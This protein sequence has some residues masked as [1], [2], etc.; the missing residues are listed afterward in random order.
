MIATYPG[1]PNKYTWDLAVHELHLCQAI[2][3]LNFV[4]SR[5]NTP[6]SDLFSLWFAEGGGCK[7]KPLGK[8][9]HQVVRVVVQV[10]QVG[11][12]ISGVV[13]VV[14]NP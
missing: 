10:V 6:P 14:R 8:G 13:G 11:F 5:K 1:V 4:I 3:S 2:E 9:S 12:R 7:N